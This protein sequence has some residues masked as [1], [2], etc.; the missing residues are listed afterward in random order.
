MSTSVSNDNSSSNLGFEAA[1][2]VEA[3]GPNV[4]LKVIFLD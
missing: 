1:G 4:D 3:V 2:I